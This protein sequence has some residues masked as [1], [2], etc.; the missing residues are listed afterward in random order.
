MGP[1]TEVG[2]YIR[3]KIAEM[4]E[5]L[6]L[7][8]WTLKP[9]V[10]PLVDGTAAC[11]AWPEYKVA[12]LTFDIDKL[13]TGDEL[14]EIVAHEMMHCHTWAIFKMA[15]DLAHAFA[16]SAPETLRGALTKLVLEQVR[17]AGED[18]NTQCGFTVIR[19]YRRWKAA[20]ADA[21]DLRRAGR[22][23]RRAQKAYMADRG[24]DALGQEVART[25]A[26][27]DACLRE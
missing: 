14:D 6:G 8:G 17:Q 21:H 13:Q 25:A 22:A 15:E 7:T 18:S 5:P 3:S 10:E 19:L 2:R 1:A 24:N 4:Q 12:H 26:L 27:L 9:V 20:Q 23:L 11:D 16:E